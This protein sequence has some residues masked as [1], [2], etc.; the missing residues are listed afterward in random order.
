[1]DAHLVSHEV[2]SATAEANITPSTAVKASLSNEDIRTLTDMA[3]TT[4]AARATRTW[5][6][7]TENKEKQVNER[8]SM[9]RAYQT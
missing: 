7:K 4:S 2:A 8:R 9:Q 3:R 5:N 6:A 1:M